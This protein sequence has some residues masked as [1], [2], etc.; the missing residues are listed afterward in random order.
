MSSEPE[1]EGD[2]EVRKAPGRGTR[3]AQEWAR[4]IHVCTS[5]ICFGVVL[6]FAA[7]GI[8]VN[9]PNWVFG[10]AGSRTTVSGTLPANWR[11]GTTVD[12]LAVAEHLRNHDGVRG[13]VGGYRSD[14]TQ[15]TIDFAGPGYAADAFIDVETG[16]YELTIDSKGFLAVLNDLHKGRDTASSWKWLIDVAGGLLVAISLSGIVLQVFLRR[17]RRAALITAAAGAAIVA[18]LISITVA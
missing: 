1:S 16:T 18:V 10:D 3:R 9:H 17:R 2:V 11:T 4:L 5:M 12:W 7:T 6:F 8:T 14:D 13:A 15:G